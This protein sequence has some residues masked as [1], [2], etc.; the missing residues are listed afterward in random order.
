MNVDE[1]RGV[2]KVGG[3]GVVSA[4]PYGKNG[5]T[6]CTYILVYIE[7]ILKYIIRLEA[8]TPTFI[9]ITL[10]TEYS[11]QANNRIQFSFIVSKYS[12][13]RTESG[14]FQSTIA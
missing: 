7:C 10:T 1:A 6:L 13:F 11:R 12:D 4:Y 8:V 3:V 14:N 2:C 5:D 9:T